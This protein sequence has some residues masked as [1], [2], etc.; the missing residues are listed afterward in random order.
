MSWKTNLCLIFLALYIHETTSV[1]HQFE[2][3]IMNG[4]GGPDDT[5]IT[6]CWSKD[7]DLGT[8]VLLTNQ[9]HS[10]AFRDQFLKWKHTVFYCQFKWNNLYKKFEVINTSWPNVCGKKNTAGCRTYRWWVRS[11]GF[12]L[13]ITDHPVASDFVFKYP[14]DGTHSVNV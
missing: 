5:L 14:W 8:H 4:L 2:V 13:A 10:W 9:E 11:N 6:H 7:D 1:P 12:Y 3:H